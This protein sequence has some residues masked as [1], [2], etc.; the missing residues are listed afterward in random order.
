[1]TKSELV[2]QL[3]YTT[4]GLEEWRHIALEALEALRVIREQVNNI[5]CKYPSN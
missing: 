5:V 1:M 4:K 2:D 3:E